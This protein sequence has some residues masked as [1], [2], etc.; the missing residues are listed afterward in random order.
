VTSIIIGNGVQPTEAILH[1]PS[2]L[3]FGNGNVF[4][5]LECDG[6]RVAVSRPSEWTPDLRTPQHPV[7]NPPRNIAHHTVMG[8]ELVDEFSRWVGRTFKVFPDLQVHRR[9]CDLDVSRRAGGLFSRLN[10]RQMIPRL[11]RDPGQD[12]GL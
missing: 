12:L 7:N 4:R 8:H 6:K 1:C 10:F 9:W 2:L 11:A 3:Q 5:C